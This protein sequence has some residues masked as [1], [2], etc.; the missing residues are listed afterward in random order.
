VQNVKPGTVVQGAIWLDAATGLY[1][2][3]IAVQGGRPIVTSV[4]AAQ[5]HGEVFTDVYFVVEHQPNSCSEYPADGGIVFEDIAIAWESGASPAWAVKQFKPA[6]NS[7]GK[8]L[9]ASSLQF[10]WSTA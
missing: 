8:V 2:Q 1:K 10:T 4:T 9:N 5:M 7:Q 6:C 3:S